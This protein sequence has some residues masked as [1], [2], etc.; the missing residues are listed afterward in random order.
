MTP[1]T[2]TPTPINKVR[3]AGNNR[4]ATNP[5]AAREAEGST[6]RNGRKASAEK[7]PAALEIE[8]STKQNCR[9]LRR[10]ALAPPTPTGNTEKGSTNLHMYLFME[11]R[12]S[13]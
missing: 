1:I 6:G 13:A 12:N 8:Y 4:V 11:S 2:L 5:P 9:R 10:N 3:K 7:H